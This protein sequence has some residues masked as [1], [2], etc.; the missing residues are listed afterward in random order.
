MEAGVVGMAE[1]MD[2]TSIRSHLVLWDPFWPV[3]GLLFLGATRY[4]ETQGRV[5]EVPHQP[6]T[7]VSAGE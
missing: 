2:A 3:G 6:R 4:F 7:G 5:G 1:S